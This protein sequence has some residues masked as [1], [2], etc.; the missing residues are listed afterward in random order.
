M[1]KQ[2]ALV[3]KNNKKILKEDVGEYEQFFKNMYSIISNTVQ[4]TLVNLSAQLEWVVLSKNISGFADLTETHKHFQEKVNDSKKLYEDAIPASIKDDVD[5]LVGITN[6]GFFLTKKTADYL[7]NADGIIKVLPFQKFVKSLITNDFYKTSVENWGEIFGFKFNNILWYNGFVYQDLLFNNI[8]ELKRLINGGKIKIGE[9]S[10]VDMNDLN[11]KFPVF[12]FFFK[13]S[14][15]LETYL[16]PQL[17]FY[18]FF[19]NQHQALAQIIIEEAQL[20]KEPLKGTAAWTQWDIKKT[21]IQTLKTNFVSKMKTDAVNGMARM[22]SMMPRLYENM[23]NEPWSGSQMYQTLSS[24]IAITDPALETIQQGIK[25]AVE[26]AM[27][28]STANADFYKAF[29]ELQKAIKNAAQTETALI[30]IKKNQ[31]ILLEDI[32][33]KTS[34]K[35]LNKQD[36]ENFK[37]DKNQQT[38]FEL[39][40]SQKDRLLDLFDDKEKNEILENWK[41]L[42][43]KAKTMSP[44][45]SPKQKA[46]LILTMAETAN[47]FFDQI[48]QQTE[49]KINQLQDQESEFSEKYNK[50]LVKEIGFE[51]DP[52]GFCKKVTFDFELYCKTIRMMSILHMMN[53]ELIFKQVSI[54]ELLIDTNIQDS[55]IL[56]AI[57]ELKQNIENTKKEISSDNVERRFENLYNQI[58]KEFTEESQTL[59]NFKKTK[60]G[61]QKEFEKFEKSIQDFCENI[62]TIIT[63]RAKMKSEI[64][65]ANYNIHLI[66]ECLKYMK[67]LN[68]KSIKIKTELNKIN[69]IFSVNVKQSKEDIN[70]NFGEIA[71]KINLKSVD[72]IYNENYNKIFLPKYNTCIRLISPS[73]SQTKFSQLTDKFNQSKIQFENMV[74]QDK[75]VVKDIK[76]NEKDSVEK[77]ITTAVNNSEKNIN[78]INVKQ[79]N[80]ENGD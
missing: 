58:K 8:N 21:H 31:I 33:N 13:A 64:E 29:D 25:T 59:S 22:S 56:S 74:N 1:K 24:T 62:N 65:K 35:F 9:A 16:S 40:D 20:G 39:S 19:K 70:K 51:A 69:S 75:A 50:N 73:G 38:G 45:N 53:I 67:Q 28:R 48:F 43:S 7:L 18:N 15:F 57:N 49:K 5:A 52:T 42:V 80:T 60:D 11:N 34:N 76:K 12:S 77:K 14:D 44:S 32:S 78:P 10:I 3:I 17:T 71:A 61:K 26:T 63:E 27:P 36:L 55:D 4:G 30:R 79:T 47:R 37:L 6:P 41:N 2:Y 72:D 54:F 66:D 68:D 46:L 23:M